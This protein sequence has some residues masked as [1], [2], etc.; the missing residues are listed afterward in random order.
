LRAGYVF[1]APVRELIIA[2]DPSSFADT[3]K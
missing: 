1:V 2:N 3:F